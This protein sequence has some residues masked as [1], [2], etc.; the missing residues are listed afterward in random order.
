MV[1]SNDQSVYHDVKTGFL[2]ISLSLN[3]YSI[4]AIKRA[5]FD[6]NDKFNIAIKT[7]NAEE[8]QITIT[9]RD[10][11]L[12]VNQELVSLF[13]QLVRDHQLRIELEKQYNVIRKIIIAQAF[14]PCDNLR[15]ILDVLDQ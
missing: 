7:R 6:L 9:Q 1:I 3:V 4:T 13:E 15:E 14:Q 2:V 5:A 10:T 12:E 8:V 11:C